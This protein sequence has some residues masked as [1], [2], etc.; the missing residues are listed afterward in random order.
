MKK[1]Q[2]QDKELDKKLKKIKNTLPRI[3]K[4]LSLR[5]TNLEFNPT[6]I[7]YH[8]TSKSDILTSEDID[9]LAECLHQN[10]NKFHLSMKLLF[11]SS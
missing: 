11:K 2:T 8:D 10:A 9:F 6:N 1:L 4:D 5:L 7:Q 3:N